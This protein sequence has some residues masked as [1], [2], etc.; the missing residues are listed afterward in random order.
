MKMKSKK[1][2]GPR[3]LSVGPEAGG[4]QLFIHAA[5]ARKGEK[6]DR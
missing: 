3:L 2:S 4:A 1:A 5:D 6:K